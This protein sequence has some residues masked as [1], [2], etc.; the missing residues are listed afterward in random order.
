MAAKPKKKSDVT[1]PFEANIPQPTLNSELSPEAPAFFNNAASSFQARDQ[2][3]ADSPP[4]NKEGGPEQQF[5]QMPASGF[6]NNTQT[7]FAANPMNATQFSS[8]GEY[9][10]QKR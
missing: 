7:S 9:D 4:D 3:Q 2:A 6:V 5:A 10:V 8:M 1:A